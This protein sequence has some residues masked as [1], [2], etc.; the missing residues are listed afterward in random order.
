LWLIL[1]CFLDT[2]SIS[3]F[4]R[5]ES[6]MTKLQLASFPTVYSSFLNS[7]TREHM[8]DSFDRKRLHLSS[9]C[10]TR[11]FHWG[12][13]PRLLY[14]LFDFKNRA[15][16]VISINNTDCN[17]IYINTNINTWS[18]ALSPNFNHKV[19]YSWFILFCL[20]NYKVFILFYKFVMY[21]SPADFC[22]WFWLKVK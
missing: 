13:T 6:F 4:F 8:T 20:R 18:M 22:E 5:C 2:T 15:I 11:N 7:T 16:K 1:K 9:R 17:C 10:T 14:N 21:L 12:L 3:P 19:Q